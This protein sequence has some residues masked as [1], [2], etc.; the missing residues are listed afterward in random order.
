MADMD[1]KKTGFKSKLRRNNPW[2]K[3]SFISAILELWKIMF[4]IDQNIDGTWQLRIVC[5][6]TR[7]D[8]L[9]SEVSEA[10]QGT[11]YVMIAPL[12]SQIASSLQESGRKE[13]LFV[14]S[15]LF[16]LRNLQILLIFLLSSLDILEITM[17]GHT[18]PKSTPLSSQPL[19]DCNCYTPDIHTMPANG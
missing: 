7:P 6:H 18:V 13:R 17:F 1:K 16:H 12:D 3:I 19:A 9:T 5:C 11:P 4:V 2:N 8:H 15:L 10:R 14:I